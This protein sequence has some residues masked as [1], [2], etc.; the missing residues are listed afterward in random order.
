MVWDSGFEDFR[1]KAPI[2]LE[3][4]RFRFGD[5]EVGC[6]HSKLRVRD[7]DFSFMAFFG[8]GLSV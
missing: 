8:F 3:A 7:Q 2:R 1:A 4:L 5:L 6:G